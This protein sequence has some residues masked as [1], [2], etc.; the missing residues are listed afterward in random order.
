MDKTVERVREGRP[1]ENRGVSTGSLTVVFGTTIFLSAVLLFS[2]QPLVGK[3]LLP[4]LGGAPSVWNTVMV[5]FQA[6]LLAGYAYAHFSSQKLGRLQP[7][8]HVVLLVIAAVFLPFVI[9]ASPSEQLHTTNPALWTLL[10]LA[11]HI[12]PPIFV[13]A[14][15]AP[16][17][18]KWF[19]G[20][21]HSAAKDPYFL[22]AASNLG[23]F[24]ALFAYP[25]LVEPYSHLNFQVRT[26]AFGFWLLVLCIAACAFLSRNKD[27]AVQEALSSETALA[28]LP[29]GT[30]WKWIGLSFVPSSLMLG[31]THYITTDVAS[32]P[33]LWV[34]PLALYLFTFV[35][36][37]SKHSKNAEFTSSRAVPIL[38][39][40][41]VFAILVQATEPVV[42]LV[43]MHLLF[44]LF[45]TLQ[46]HLK[47]ANSRPPAARLTQFYLC[48]SLGGVLGGI[49]NALI[50]PLIFQSII[51]YPLMI[52]IATLIGF[53]VRQTRKPKFALPPVYGGAVVIL[54]FA[55]A[56]AVIVIASA[57][58]IA[59]GNI[60]GGITVL[61]CY[62]FVRRPVR[63]ALAL[64]TLLLFTSTFRQTHNKIIERDRNFFGVL[65][66]A[67]DNDQSLRRLYHGTTIH[68]IQFRSAE[69]K[70]EPS[71]YYHR[72]GPVAQITALYQ[73]SD[74]PKNV[75]LIG[76]GAGA[77]LTYSRPDETWTV[78][79]IDPAVLRVAQDPQFFT[80]MRDCTPGK[81]QIELGDARLRLQSAPD[82]Q[83]GL[84]FIDA[85]SSDVI[86]MH[87][88]TLEAI[89]LY[90]QKLVPDGVLAFHLSSRHF[91]LEPL[92]A[93]L[94]K[95]LGLHCF[96]STRGDLGSKALQEGGFDSTWAI[97]VP[98]SRLPN[99]LAQATWMRVDPK[100][101]SPLWTDDFSSLVGVLRF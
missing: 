6:M 14:S 32:V 48:M 53:P 80:Y 19:A 71:S 67:D 62:I 92:V 29:K 68:G 9:T 22:Y 21:G 10:V 11:K 50:A 84:I 51:E 55:I 81:Y 35:I 73:Q 43:L 13:L 40:A 18:Q 31:V 75:G 89:K 77:M 30:V 56:S 90:R 78:Y 41:V 72:E 52:V 60:L 58:S 27:A 37:F 23:S 24:G 44:F 42:V 96:T 47:L 8:V 94:G 91:E 100:E 59:I 97:L 25:L 86:P 85:F 99:V 2:V 46:C 36:A 63:Y 64:G 5:F 57:R 66:V 69:R 87:L 26:W 93:N 83:Y 49:F 12:G 61:C 38:A 76:L 17:L 7:V 70:C 16:L 45:A 33:L 39:I 28:P 4:L 20:T 3:L 79:E 101:N 54:A 74:L 88:L 98:E 15:T 95:S 82:G 34:L 1:T 65:R